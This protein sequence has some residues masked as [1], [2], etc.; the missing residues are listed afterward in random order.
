MRFKDG[1]CES[2]RLAGALGARMHIVDVDEDLKLHW[3][4]QHWRLNEAFC[5]KCD[6]YKNPT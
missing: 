1:S 2:V 3:L 5:T 4:Q 6:K